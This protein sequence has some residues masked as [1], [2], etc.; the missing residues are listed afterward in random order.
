MK[1]PSLL[2]TSITLTGCF[3]FAAGRFS[4]RAIAD[5]MSSQAGSQKE[6]NSELHIDRDSSGKVVVTWNGKGVLKHA[7]MLSGHFKPVRNR[8]NTLVTEAEGDQMLFRVE[9]ASGAVFSANIVGYV[10]TPFPPGLTLANNPLRSVTDNVE[11][12]FSYG[13][14][15][16]GAQVLKYVPSLGYEISTFD[17]D[18]G[19]WSNPGMTLPVGTGFFFSNP[20]TNTVTHTFVGEVR[21]GVLVNPLPAGF[22]TKGALVPQEGSIN[23]VH[24]IPG[25]AGDL[26][27]LYVNDL[28]GGGEYVTS[29]FTTGV[30][31]VP[32]LTLGIAKGFV[33]EKQNAQNWVRVFNPWP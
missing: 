26:L 5:Q 16:D 20:S 22:S 33:S 31:W 28:Q 18:A 9:A 11:T 25:E 27:R 12:L 24:G 1:T 8:G 13:S 30:G 6:D 32:D 4:S 2:L 21:V 14:V 3:L 19:T 23:S 15:P 29:V 7:S 17:H 10:T